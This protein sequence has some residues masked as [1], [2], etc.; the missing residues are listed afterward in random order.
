MSL[1]QYNH[2]LPCKA[3]FNLT[4]TNSPTS[5][6]TSMLTMSHCPVFQDRKSALNS[7]LTTAKNKESRCLTFKLKIVQAEVPNQNR[8]QV[9]CQAKVLFSSTTSRLKVSPFP[10]STQTQRM[11]VPNKTMSYSSRTCKRAFKKWMPKFL[12]FQTNSMKKRN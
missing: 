9:Q 2:P 3:P 10:D 4:N 5:A 8:V 7:L 12:I 1:R 6:S 11:E